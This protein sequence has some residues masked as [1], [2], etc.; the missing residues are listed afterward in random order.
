MSESATVRPAL[1]GALPPR[2]PGAMGRGSISRS[3]GDAWSA[4]IRGAPTTRCSSGSRSRRSMRILIVASGSMRSA[5][6][7]KGSLQRVS[8]AT[9]T[10]RSWEQR[11][12]PSA[13][14]SCGRPHSAT[15]TPSNSM[16]GPCGAAAVVRFPRPGIACRS[17]TFR[18]CRSCA[19]R[20]SRS[21]RPAAARSSTSSSRSGR[22]STRRPTTCRKSGLPRQSVATSS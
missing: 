4:P 10:T 9:T 18:T 8:S 17:S 13:R 15:F 16:S 21:G 6:S 19:G 5:N 11:I 7:S 12:S 22:S 3:S 2:R 1:H 14:R 20:A